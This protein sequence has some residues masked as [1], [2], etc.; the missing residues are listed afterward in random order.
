MSHSWL[1][2]LLYILTV[3]IEQSDSLKA[4][5]DMFQALK[6]RREALEDT[7]RKKLEE[8]KLLCLQEGVKSLI[9]FFF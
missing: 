6:A 8:L 2:S 3:T 7:L 1:I 5:R 4:E 9:F